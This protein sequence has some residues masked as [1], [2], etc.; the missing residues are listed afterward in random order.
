MVFN[1]VRDMKEELSKQIDLQEQKRWTLKLVKG[2][3]EQKARN[4]SVITSACRRKLLQEQILVYTRKNLTLSGLIANLVKSIENSSENA[5]AAILDLWNFEL[6]GQSSISRVLEA[7]SNVFALAYGM[8]KILVSVLDRLG[9]DQS[10]TEAHGL[11]GKSHTKISTSVEIH[12]RIIRTMQSKESQL[13]SACLQIQD[14]NQ[15]KK[16][17]KLENEKLASLLSESQF[18]LMGMKS[19][20]EDMVKA[21]NRNEEELKR[22]RDLLPKESSEHGTDIL[23]QVTSRIR[24]A[25]SMLNNEKSKK[26]KLESDCVRLQTEK[27]EICLKMKGIEMEL[28]ESEKEKQRVVSKLQ[29]AE[30][31]MKTV[32]DVCSKTKADHDS[33]LAKIKC[34]VEQ[35]K[36]DMDEVILWS[37]QFLLENTADLQKPCHQNIRMVQSTSYQQAPSFGEPGLPGKA[38]PLLDESDAV[39]VALLAV[40]LDRMG[41]GGASVDRIVLEVNALLGNNMEKDEVSTAFQVMPSRQNNSATNDV[42][43]LALPAHAR[44][45]MH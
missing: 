4:A 5:E 33:I 11:R 28:Q 22:I 18:A 29:E 42:V 25:W 10:E 8:E 45:R 30:Y 1:S 39:Q 20:N 21:L 9:G 17:L 26:Q 43:V 14:L 3:Q 31:N 13:T 34:S 27:E 23:S 19:A 7:D 41:V 38:K 15:E 37:G 36:A 12:G 40:L 6:G 2:G 16:D 35:L 44:M 24:S 32:L